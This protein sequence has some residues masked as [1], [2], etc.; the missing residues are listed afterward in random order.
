MT[1]QFR[2]EDRVQAA[3][4]AAQGAAKG[5]GSEPACEAID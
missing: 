1:E 3:K 4:G 2:E 5:K